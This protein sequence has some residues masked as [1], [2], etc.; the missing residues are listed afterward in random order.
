MWQTICIVGISNI[1][2]LN[3]I[4]ILVPHQCLDDKKKNEK[5]EKKRKEATLTLKK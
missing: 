3:K 5:K 1:K 2:I 4:W